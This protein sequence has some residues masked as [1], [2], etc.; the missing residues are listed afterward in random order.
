[1][2]KDAKAIVQPNNVDKMVNYV[3]VIPGKAKNGKNKEKFFHSE[4][5]IYDKY[6]EP[7]L[8][9]YHAEKNGAP[10]AMVLY[11]W[12]VPCYQQSC[13]ST[14]TTGCTSHTLKALKSY[15]DKV[16]VIVAYTTKGGGM[17]GSTKCNAEETENQLKAAGIDVLKIKYNSEEE[18][19]IED[20]IKI[21][22]L[23][24]TLE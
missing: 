17:S 9:N 21:G 2:A 3:A 20:L 22:R 16:K 23:L 19:I 24:E 18:A 8:L 1:M 7:M 12:I 6:L 13:P 15:A 14:G 10:K 4:Q 5:R 11:S